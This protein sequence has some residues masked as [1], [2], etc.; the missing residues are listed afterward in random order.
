MPR[1]VTTVSQLSG[2]N[3]DLTDTSITRRYSGSSRHHTDYRDRDSHC[4]EGSILFI[5]A[6]QDSR[7]SRAQ[8][9]PFPPAKRAG[10]SAL[11]TLFVHYFEL[12]TSSRSTQLESLDRLD[13]TVCKLGK[14]LFS[15]SRGSFV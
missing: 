15:L 7:H 1:T 11:D 12:R 4:Q 5:V 6:D 10:S 2:G 8:G 14:S 13:S 9:Y 3:R